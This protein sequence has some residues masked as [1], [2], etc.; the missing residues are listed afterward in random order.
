MILPADCGWITAH[1]EV[2]RATYTTARTRSPLGGNPVL[3]AAATLLPGTNRPSDSRSDNNYCRASEQD[4]YR[5]DESGMC[6]H[7]PLLWPEQ[8]PHPKKTTYPII[9]MLGSFLPS[10]LI[11]M[12]L[13][14][15]RVIRRQPVAG[16]GGT[17][18]WNLGG[19]TWK[20]MPKASDPTAGP[21][22]S[23]P[24]RIARRRHG[25]CSVS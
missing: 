9:N 17:K 1:P 10:L 16:E 5:A 4:S 13:K 18:K 3:P 6:E 2:I 8:C 24:R 23:L 11:V 7:D 19:S 12:Q 22:P 14:S 15:T 20:S 21:R 25:K